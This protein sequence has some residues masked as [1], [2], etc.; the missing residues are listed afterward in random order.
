MDTQGQS[1]TKRVAAHRT[2]PVRFSSFS[3][4]TKT[5]KLISVVDPPTLAD[6]YFL[7]FTTPPNSCHPREVTRLS[8]WGRPQFGNLFPGLRGGMKCHVKSNLLGGFYVFSNQCDLQFPFPANTRH[9]SA[10]AALRSSYHR[11]GAYTSEI[12]LLAVLETVSPSPRCT[13]SWFLVRALPLALQI[14]CHL[15]AGSSCDLTRVLAGSSSSVVS[16]LFS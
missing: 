12:S 4:E 1:L 11:P 8:V 16:F 7:K 14:A 5:R 2:R 3:V 6:D 15:P 10:R 9:Q 13:R